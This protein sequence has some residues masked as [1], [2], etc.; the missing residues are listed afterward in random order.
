VKVYTPKMPGTAKAFVV[1]MMLGL[2]ASIVQ[3]IGYVSVAG[4]SDVAAAFAW[5]GPLR[6]VGLGLILAGVALA[7]VAIGNVL[8]FQ[9]YRIQELIRS[10][11]RS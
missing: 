4:N 6:E 7:L 11:E 1:L 2:M 10:G 3:F 8:A 9:F 5:L